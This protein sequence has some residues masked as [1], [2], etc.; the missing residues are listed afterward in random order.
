MNLHRDVPHR[1]ATIH[2]L[3]LALV[4]LL[5][6]VMAPGAA[7]HA[8]GWAVTTLDA[9]PSL[10]PGEPIDVGFTIRQHGITPV[11]VEGA[12][13]DVVAAD[14]TATTFPAT[15]DGEAHYVATITVPDA[16]TYTWRVNQGWFAPQDL[17][18]LV[19]APAPAAMPVATPDTSAAASTPAA[20]Q[21]VET[22]H[23][24]PAVARFGLPALALVFGAMAVADL[25][26]RRRERRRSSVVA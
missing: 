16:G 11:E 15:L 25:V 13:I 22:T 1:P 6:G 17:G 8:G 23:Q 10:V 18:R 2:R 4:A 5:V 3:L 26:M 9:T 14:G 12:S 24:Y 19:V 7:V 21:V 20:V